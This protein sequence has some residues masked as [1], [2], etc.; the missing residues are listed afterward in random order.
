MKSFVVVGFSAVGS[1]Q[2]IITKV[3]QTETFFE[4]LLVYIIW[5][6]PTPYN[7]AGILYIYKKILMCSIDFSLDFL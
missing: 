3:G 6:T 7:I 4:F 5:A 2:V 1:G